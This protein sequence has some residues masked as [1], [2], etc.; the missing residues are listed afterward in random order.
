MN[1]VEI[2]KIF[3][4]IDNVFAG[5]SYDDFKVN[6]WLRILEDV[7]YTL[8]EANFYSYTRDPENKFPPTPGQLAKRPAQAAE[9]RAIPDAAETR[10]MLDNM[11]TVEEN[12]QRRAL[13]PAPP[14]ERFREEVKRIAARRD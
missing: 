3:M 14:S 7:P 5:F 9:G 12:G 10:L 8:A 13:Q 2:R 11:H 1:E 6:L 4:L